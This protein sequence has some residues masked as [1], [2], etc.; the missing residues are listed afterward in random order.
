MRAAIK[1]R[2]ERLKRHNTIVRKLS[3]MVTDAGATLYEDPFDILALLDAVGILVEAKTL[4]GSEAD[5]RDRVRESLSQLL[6][7]EV[8]VAGPVAWEV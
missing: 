5:E 4:D 3:A 2:G 1:S 8:F 6:Y 7:Y